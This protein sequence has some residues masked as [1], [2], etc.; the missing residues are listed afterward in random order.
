MS[1]AKRFVG[2]AAGAGLRIAIVTAKFNADI[3]DRMLAGA[4][5]TLRAHGVADDDVDEAAVPGSFELP[6]I[7]HRLAASGRYDAVICLGAV[8]KG[9]TSHDVYIST[10]T[11]A[12]LQ[13]AALD[14]GVPVV[15]GVITPNTHEQAMERAGGR[16]NKGSEAALT[17]IEM[18]TLLHQIAPG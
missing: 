18:A 9:A 16:T 6:L 5:E 3:T 13:R 2:S 11:A 7:A 14:T 12:G 10:G 8:I 1:L 15:F 4:R 17:A